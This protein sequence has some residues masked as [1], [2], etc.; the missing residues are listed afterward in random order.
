[1]IIDTID[2]LQEYS[3]LNPYINMVCEFLKSHDLEKLPLGKTQILGNDL[4][5]NKDSVTPKTKEEAILETHQQMIDIQIPLSGDEEHGY[6]PKKSLPEEH[7]NEEKDM[8]L[9]PIEHA[10]FFF[11]L[12]PGQFVIYL[13]GEGHAPAV[14]KEPLQKVIFKLRYKK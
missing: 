8:S 12:C 13:P 14:T 11:K 2:R 5:V 9:Y 3:D 7:Y 6:C 4:F 1:M 10:Q